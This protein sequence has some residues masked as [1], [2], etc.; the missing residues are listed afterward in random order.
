MG[1]WFAGTE[2]KWTGLAKQ[3]SKRGGDGMES[4]IACNQSLRR[5]AVGANTGL[6]N[7]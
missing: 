3:T 7:S 5:A 6:V 2:L 4:S 1:R